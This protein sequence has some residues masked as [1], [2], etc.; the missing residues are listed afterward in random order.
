[1]ELLGALHL[2]LGGQANLALLVPDGAVAL[3]AGNTENPVFAFR[4]GELEV[5]ATGLYS[6]DRSFF[7]LAAPYAADRRLV[8]MGHTAV[9]TPD[10]PIGVA[11]SL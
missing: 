6:L 3:Y 4:L 5:A 9:M 1:M 8:R 10:H 7:R 11:A 2:A